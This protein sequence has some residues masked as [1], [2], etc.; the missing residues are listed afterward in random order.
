MLR[1]LA[2]LLAFLFIHLEL[3]GL[4][5]IPPHGAALVVTNHLGDADFVLGIAM[6]PRPCEVF[7]KAELYDFPILGKLLDAYG[8]IWV[9][10][11][12]PDRKALRIALQVLE[13]GRL[14][15]IAPESRESLTGALEEGTLGAAYLALKSGVPILPVT[16]TGTD[17]RVIFAAMR[18]LKRSP[19]TFTVG[20][21]FRLPFTQNDHAARQLATEH[22]MRTL[23]AQLPPEYQG[24]Y[25]T[26]ESVGNPYRNKPIDE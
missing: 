18:R 20:P 19:V 4:E 24:I 10:R 21:A 22:I 5:H 1:A 16:F 7:A 2:R 12:Q 3:R 11:G 25:A 6:T 15:G 26:G 13:E 17:N 8:V 14:M 23:A 9:H